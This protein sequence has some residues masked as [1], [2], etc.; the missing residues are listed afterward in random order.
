M[1]ALGGM[2]TGGDSG[3]QAAFA[4]LVGAAACGGALGRPSS[5]P[6]AASGGA[7]DETEL[8]SAAA[9]LAAAL[10]VSEQR[11]LSALE[12]AGGDE[13]DALE[14]LLMEMKVREKEAEDEAYGGYVRR[15]GAASSSPRYAPTSRH[16]AG[17]DDPDDDDEPVRG[18][19]H[20][21]LRPAAAKRAA[22]AAAATRAA[23]AAKNG[24]G[25]GGEKPPASDSEDEGKFSPEILEAAEEA[26]FLLDEAVLPP[27]P[28]SESESFLFNLFGGELDVEVI[29]GE[30]RRFKGDVDRAATSL[31]DN[32]SSL[33]LVRRLEMEQAA[34]ERAA[35]ERRAAAAAA[36]AAGAAVAAEL[37]REAVSELRRKQ[38]KAA[39][40]ARKQALHNCGGVGGEGPSS[41]AA[42]AAPLQEAEA[43]REGGEESPESGSGGDNDG[44]P[45]ERQQRLFAPRETVSARVL[46]QRLGVSE[47]SAQFALEVV[48]DGD[49]VAAEALLRSTVLHPE[50]RKKAA[51]AAKSADEGAGAGAADAGAS[52]SS[53]AAFARETGS[54]ELQLDD[55]W[56]RVPRKDEEALRAAA[57]AEAEERERREAGAALRARLDT[58]A[59]ARAA[60]AE[61]KRARKGKAPVAAAATQAS[62]FSVDP[63]IAWVAGSTG[64]ASTSQ[65]KKPGPAAATAAAAVAPTL[66]PAPAA[67]SAA[68]S[69]SSSSSFLSHNLRL[70]TSQAP[71]RAGFHPEAAP[72]RFRE[73]RA[74]ADAL[75]AEFTALLDA[76][77]AARKARDAPLAAR[78]QKQAGRLKALW[79]EETTAATLRIAADRNKKHLSIRPVDL[80]GQ[81][82]SSALDF[83][84]LHLG[85]ELGVHENIA[86]TSGPVCLRFMV[87]KGLHSTGGVQKLRGPVTELILE[88]GFL[89]ATEVKW[90]PQC[91]SVEVT[92][93]PDS[94]T[95]ERRKE[96]LEN[97]PYAF[98][99]V[100]AKYCGRGGHDDNGGR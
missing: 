93:A 82:V 76:A 55:G 17:Y 6:Q 15:G 41:S 79:V 42:A 44:R 22:A 70:P 80:H 27:A 32:G 11:A 39:A 10:G 74:R 56:Q 8:A 40:K 57:A 77:R 69:S 51:A 12:A 90:E 21:R 45:E 66:S 26:R 83:V 29:L 30:L 23:A 1:R 78:L 95:A 50:R 25:A 19:V 89:R 18:A 88:T 58:A 48:E 47:A 52:S 94:L 54:E 34:E 72:V 91:A 4:A 92:L 37:E 64:R 63:A 53:S 2:D 81:T 61:E 31:F 59:A 65:E 43:R 98:E 20:E 28:P 86:M 68:S 97:L 7:P 71:V 38:K 67:A 99:D 84:N 100:K 14:M 73:Q 24:G 35:A 16:G 5:G 60:A 85:H 46:A 3:A 96:L 9:F 13:D 87:G 75:F 36:E 49:P 62:S 33:Q